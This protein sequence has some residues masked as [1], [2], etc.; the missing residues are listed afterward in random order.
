MAKLNNLVLLA[1]IFILTPSLI[2]IASSPELPHRFRYV[3]DVPTVG[4]YETTIDPLNPG[5][6]LN[7]TLDPYSIRVLAPSGNE[8]PVYL[9]FETEQPIKMEGNIERHNSFIFPE[10][11]GFCFIGTSP[12]AYVKILLDRGALD[13][14]HG[15]TFTIK[16]NF[17]VLL[18]DSS[19]PTVIAEKDVVSEK[20]SPFYMRYDPSKLDEKRFYSIFLVPRSGIGCI[21]NLNL[22]SGKLIVRWNADVPGKYAIYLDTFHS[23]PRLVNI[24]EGKRVEIENMEGFQIIPRF[25]KHLSGNV[26]LAVEVVGNS[27]EIESVQA[28]IDYEGQYNWSD[29]YGVLINFKPTSK[30]IWESKWNT[31]TTWDGKHILVIRAFESSGRFAESKVEVRI[32]NVRNGTILAPDKKEFTFIVMG[33]NRPSGGI[34]QPEVYRQLLQYMIREEPDLY[35]NVGDIVYSGELREYEDFVRVTSLIKGP[36]FIA[37]GNHEN[38]IGEKGQENFIDYFGKLFYSFDY[39]NSHF[40]ILNANIPG[41][42]YSMSDEQISWLE[43]D[44]S[45]STASHNFIFIHQ[46]IYPYAHGLEDEIAEKKLRAVLQAHKVDLVFQGHEH[47]FYEGV[48]DGIRY[49]ITGGGGAELDTQY[50][51]ECLFF[52][53]IVVRVS[54]G[55]VSYRIVKPPVLEIEEIPSPI[56]SSSINIRGRVQPFALVRVNGS[57][58][59]PSVSGAFTHE[60]NLKPGLNRIIVEAIYDKERLY[61]EIL[62]EYNP[63]SD[64]EIEGNPLSGGE[65][66]AYV[67]CMGKPADGT[68]IVGKTKY[69]L[70]DGRAII[71]LP[72]VNE[73]ENIEIVSIVK[74][75]YATRKVLKVFPGSPPPPEA[76]YLISIVILI[77]AFL[78]YNRRVGKKAPPPF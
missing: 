3:V 4:S 30:G 52:H 17:T 54:G 57:E 19:L 8:V 64:I 15:F 51:S 60:V 49:V 22:V 41:H 11:N 46:P 28:R 34:K 24:T 48:E 50:P 1:A 71:K 43:E 65:V 44:L 75:C 9:E 74:G 53:Y 32:E 35:F 72:I 36:L 26:S 68:L 5:F 29:P 66:E 40:V 58:V 62:V 21:S 78:I 61:K 39:G 76:T 12:D 47:M 70:T 37:E 7:D 63:H 13:S 56:D 2:P 14:S 73:E 16:G 18:K 31:L 45:R 10:N 42:R 27:T 38:T 23:P 6:Y 55:E 59:K 77:A 69:A 67:T 20:W 25:R 33:D